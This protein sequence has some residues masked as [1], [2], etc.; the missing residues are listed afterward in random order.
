[1]EKQH[2]GD[3]GVDVERPLAKVTLDQRALFSSRGSWI[4]SFDEEKLEINKM[5]TW[6]SPSHHLTRN[7]ESLT[8]LQIQTF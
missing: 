8:A 3:E 6:Y 5:R 1:V 7:S 4:L 2:F